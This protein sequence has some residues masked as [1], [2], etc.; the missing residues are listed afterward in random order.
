MSIDRR[1]REGLDRTAA[2]GPDADIEQSL[3]RVHTRRRRRRH[4]R[5]GA[6]ALVAATLATGAALGV[7]A[8]LDE[9]RT[10]RGSTV[11]APAPALSLPGMYVVDVGDSELAEQNGMTGRWVIELR[12]NGGVLFEPPEAFQSPT[13]GISYSVEGNE[14]RVDAFSTDPLC[15]V[16]QVSAPVSTYRWDRTEAMLRFTPVS[17]TCAARQLLFAGQPWIVQP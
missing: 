7:P 2:T 8:V 9:L 3:S 17:E 15:F 16:S 5:R 10:P 12:E 1:L 4:V 11:V 6:L 14:M 13:S